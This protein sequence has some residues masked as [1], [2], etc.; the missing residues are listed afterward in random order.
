MTPFLWDIAFDHC[1]FAAQHFKTVD[2]WAL[3]LQIL[4]NAIKICG[5]H[6]KLGVYEDNPCS[7]QELKEKSI[8]RETTNKTQAMHV[9][10]YFQMWG[11]LR[12]GKPV[13]Q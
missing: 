3:N 2:H 9:K 4:T 8:Q 12:N 7:L 13:L 6:W 1:M 5:V 10:K 11:L